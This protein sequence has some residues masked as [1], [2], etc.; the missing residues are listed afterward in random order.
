MISN[1]MFITPNELTIMYQLWSCLSGKG[2]LES[3]AV[4]KNGLPNINFSG[5]YSFMKMGSCGRTNSFSRL[6]TSPSFSY[7]SILHALIYVSACGASVDIVELVPVRLFKFLIATKNWSVGS[8]RG[9]V[10]YKPRSSWIVSW[11]NEEGEGIPCIGDASLSFGF[12][13]SVGA[14]CCW[15]HVDQEEL[16][17]AELLVDQEELAIAELLVDQEELALVELTVD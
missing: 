12:S 2:L 7:D 8:K 11:G 4:I 1:V 13:V 14:I 17:V 16:A 5:T 9:I 3:C 6:Y 15:G 10:L